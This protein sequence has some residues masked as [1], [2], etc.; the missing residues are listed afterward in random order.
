FWFHPLVWWIRLRLVE[1]RE[2]ACDEEVLRTATDP[3]DYAEGIVAVCRYYLKSPL[4]CVSAVTGANL[5]RRVVAIMV[6]QTTHRLNAGRRLLLAA[7]GFAA[8]VLP[9]AVGVF[10]IPHVR[11][12]QLSGRLEFDAVSVKASNPNSTNGTVVSI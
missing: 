1:E 4:V 3:Q 5:K 11:A 2:R 6:N 9:I 12:Q 7:A 10:H 8:V